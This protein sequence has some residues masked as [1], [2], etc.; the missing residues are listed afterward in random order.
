MFENTGFDYFDTNSA[1]NASVSINLERCK[2]IHLHP[3]LITL[4][5]D[6]YKDTTI[7]QHL[8]SKVI[9]A[10]LTHDDSN[11]ESIEEDLER[12]HEAVGRGVKAKDA[13]RRFCERTFQ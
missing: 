9:C 12:R 6:P 7:K 2:Q 13:Y 11:R 10:Q 5:K 8:E 3:S 4:T 1:P